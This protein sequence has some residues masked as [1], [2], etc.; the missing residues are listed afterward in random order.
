MKSQHAQTSWEQQQQTG[1]CTNS[2]LE[3]RLENDQ[4]RMDEERIVRTI[5]NLLTNGA[6]L[7]TTRHNGNSFVE[8]NDISLGKNTPGRRSARRRQTPLPGSGYVDNWRQPTTP[9]REVPFSP[10]QSPEIISPP[11][12]TM[13]LTTS[14]CSAPPLVAISPNPDFDFEY[15]Q[16]HVGNETGEFVSNNEHDRRSQSW[17]KQK[18]AAAI[19]SH[20]QPLCNFCQ[21]AYQA[22]TERMLNDAF[23][24]DDSL[25]EGANGL[26][27][28]NNSLDG[29]LS[30]NVKIPRCVVN[31]NM[32][33]T[34]SWDTLNALQE[35]TL[36]VSFATVTITVRTLDASARVVI[37]IWGTVTRFNPFVWVNQIITR[38]FNMMGMT[39][40]VVVSGIQSVATGVGS[41]SSIALNRL[42]AKTP[43]STGAVRSPAKSKKIM[44]HKLL[45]K[46]N[47]LNSTAP[48]VSYTELEDND[49]GL[50]K[51]AKSK[52][53]RMMHYDVSLRPFLATVKSQ[54]LVKKESSGSLPYYHDTDSQSSSPID[55]P[56]MCTPQSF[57]A[58]P[59][60][61]AHVMKRGS[62]FSDD[63][64]FLARDQLRVHDGLESENETTREM[65]Q[66][67]TQGNRLAV[68]DA[69]DASA[70]IE[71]S[72]G[73]HGKMDCCDKMKVHS[74]VFLLINFFDYSC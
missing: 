41:A 4:D 52:V 61:R 48:V 45:R 66:A 56:F 71:F 73:Q 34:F 18:L 17:A 68:F 51:H 46:L 60:S 55:G 7:G 6:L 24:D 59:A 29:T 40:E 26:S 5:A 36:D 28:H 63:V 23:T 30:H 16:Q 64:I 14:D 58:T 39:T 11:T 47:N 10:D 67:L 57:P 3:S 13:G 19:F 15:S 20:P 54:K 38:P 25:T 9:E 1:E 21:E 65:A 74:S 72:C 49:G 42:S 12:I 33:L 69:D 62:R 43:L 8:E 2:S 53:Q 70:G 44:N 31:S 37:Y 32:I 50:S 35:M 27:I 22:T